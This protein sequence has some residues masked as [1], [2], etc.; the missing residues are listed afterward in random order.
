[1]DRI[2]AIT[3]SKISGKYL[4]GNK[5]KYICIMKHLNQVCYS[6]LSNWGN[7]NKE[8]EAEF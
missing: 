7:S 3:T 8:I 6:F 1:M 2:L 4:T 5:L